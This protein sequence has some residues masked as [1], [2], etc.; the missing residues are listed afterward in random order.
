M[1]NPN[2]SWETTMQVF[3]L[4]WLVLASGGL[5]AHA[6]PTSN[7]LTVE[8]INA[9]HGILWKAGTHVH[10]QM[11]GNALYN[12][13]GSLV[14]VKPDSLARVLALPKAMSTLRESEIPDSF[15]SATR[16]PHCAKVI[17]DIR[18]QSNCGCC[19][20]FSGASAA[21]DRMCIA[22]NGSLVEPLSAQELCF[23]SS[24]DGCGG[25]QI[26][27]PWSYILTQGAV[28]GGQQTYAGNGTDPDPFADSGL[29]SQF[30]LPHCHHHGP[31]VFL[32]Y[33]HGLLVR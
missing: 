21:S 3:T 10:P 6:I 25:G 28:T 17:N 16:W 27:T 1:A 31:Q 7:T 19:W 15:D 5:K 13:R 33:E 30:S 20:A 32:E 4:C 22:S 14:G 24:S 12:N 9:H 11:S 23:C 29:C 26:D 2:I 8:E 18:D